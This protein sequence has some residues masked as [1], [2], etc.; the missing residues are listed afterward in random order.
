M[1]P[2]EWVPP[3]LSSKDRKGP[4]YET[5]FFRIPNV[6]WSPKTVIQ[7]A[8]IDHS[9]LP[10]DTAHLLGFGGEDAGDLELDR[11]SQID[12][13]LH[14]SWFVWSSRSMCQW[15]TYNLVS[16]EQFVWPVW[17]WP[18]PQRYCQCPPNPQSK[19]V[20]DWLKETDISWQGGQLIWCARIAHYYCHWKTLPYPRSPR[21]ESY[22]ILLFSGWSKSCRRVETPVNSMITLAVLPESVL[23]NLQLGQFT[24]ENSSPLHQWGKY[25][26]LG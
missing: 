6:G 8:I 7:R 23:Q 5:V 2:T 22:W 21:Q 1:E 18:H 15:C 4:V 25:G 19:A 12:G 3:T 17:A 24:A 11:V 16:I 10:D 9:F 13:M 14:H 20:L 26:M